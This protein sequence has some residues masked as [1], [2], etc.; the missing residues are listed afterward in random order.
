[1]ALPVDNYQSSLALTQFLPL[2]GI[3]PSQGGGGATPGIP[4]GSIRTFAGNFAFGGSALAE[5]QLLPINQNTALF[6]LLGFM[7]G[8]NGTSMF[9]LPDLDGRTLIGGPPLPPP[10]PTRPAIGSSGITL[11]NAQLPS[12]LGGSSQPIDN[13]QPSL[14]ITYLIRTAGIFPSEFG[15]TAG[16]DFMGQI[17]PFA[18]NFAPD[19]FLEAAGQTLQIADY[20]DLFSLIG[21]TYGGDG[22]ETFQLPDLRGRTIVGTSSTQVPLGLN[23][24]EAQA[25]LSNANL[26]V[27]LGG[28]GYGI[29]NH[30]PSLALTYLISLTGIFPSSQSGGVHETEQYLGEIV[31]FAGTF[32]PRGWAKA[33]GQILSIN[34]H[35]ALF[36]LLG[37]MYGGNGQTTFAL[38]DLR[39]RTAI[40][41]GDAADVGDILGSNYATVLSSNIFDLQL[42]GT[43]DPNALNGGAGNDSLDGAGGADAMTGGAGNDVYFVDNAGDA[44][45][46]NAGA[47]NDV[48]FSTAH[49]A[50]AANVEILNLQGG[51]NLQGYG[52]A[53][54]NKLFGNSGNNLLDG[55]ASADAMN[56]GAGNDVYFVDNAGDN[57]TES[58]GQGNDVVFA[59][60]HF[61][62]SANVEK[63]VL[64][65]GADLQGYGNG[66]ANTL[67]GN[68][69]NNLL[70]GG[71]G[72]DIMRGGAGNDVYFVDDAG[73]TATE[74]AGEGTD[75]VFASAHFALSANVETLVL[76]GSADLQ[77]FGNDLANTIY[78]NTGGNL[79][80]G[81]TGADLMV[82]GA[83]NDT[84]FADDT[85]DSAFESAGEG[86]DAVS[87]APT[88]GWR[89]T[90]RSWCCKGAPT[91]RATAAAR[92]TRSTATPATICSTAAPVA[93]PCMAGSAT[94]PTLST[95]AWIRRSRT[96]ARAPMPSLPRSTSSCRPTWKPWCSK[97]P[98]I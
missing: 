57:V 63:L 27:S 65:G 35:Q 32:A 68:T 13:Y 43:S 38:P 51:A 69:G 48:V 64:Q 54:A 36:S 28:I 5:G 66:L 78:G 94:T 84:Y 47:G 12:M 15:G 26:P 37:T 87:P 41:T 40:G 76:Q 44:V 60:A 71:I 50:L 45:I 73:D 34:Q 11:S 21:T 8:G 58:A 56:G 31:P 29:D 74:N 59:S 23:V 18:G 14:P 4:L 46:E 75:A 10:D 96:P 91:C 19:G 88:T 25:T 79:L 20:I 24:G 2:S 52:N 39:D 95:T 1:M 67:T 61:A 30:Q 83:G 17:V 93:T 82:G 70:D 90:W 7:Y 55:G 77:G 97:G 72:A 6:S 89:R 16:V 33:E 81:G 9:A 3:F 42:T 92:R 86:T 49:L 53:L 22:F 62:L 98:P 85:S 80:D